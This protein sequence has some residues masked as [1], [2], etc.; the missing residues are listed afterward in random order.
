[1]NDNAQVIED[2]VGGSLS[3]PPVD[4]GGRRRV[5]A[6]MR[7]WSTFLHSIEREMRREWDTFESVPGIAPRKQC[8]ILKNLA[9]S[10]DDDG[11]SW[12]ESSKVGVMNQSNSWPS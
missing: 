9:P 8:M 1:M 12:N 4:H 6:R 3:V 5:G 2:V 7:R 10:Y 11:R